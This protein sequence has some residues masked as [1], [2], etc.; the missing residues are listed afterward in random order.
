[1]ESKLTLDSSLQDVFDDNKFDEIL[2]DQIQELKKQLATIK[3]VKAGV[4]AF[5][6]TWQ[7]KEMKYQYI[8][9]VN[10]KSYCT[11]IQKQLILQLINRSA[12][13][14]IKHYS[15]PI[16]KFVN[17]IKNLKLL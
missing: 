17:S 12:I 4:F 6:N 3:K 16:N 1:M 9:I 15:L 11:S 8:L 14:T 5:L 2:L 13:L 10:R 7:I